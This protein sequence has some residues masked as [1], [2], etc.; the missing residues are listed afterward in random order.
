MIRMNKNWKVPAA[1][2]TPCTNI[3]PLHLC[4]LYPINDNYTALKVYMRT[5]EP[6][7]RVEVSESG[8]PEYPISHGAAN[9]GCRVSDNHC[10]K[11]H[12][13]LVLEAF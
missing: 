12:T 8:I 7:G 9:S 10:S 2:A 11:V 5:I 6:Q 13:V 1:A 3:I 4:A